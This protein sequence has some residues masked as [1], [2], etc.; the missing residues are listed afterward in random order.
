MPSQPDEVGTDSPHDSSPDLR[1][2]QVL[3][4]GMV[5]R[6]ESGGVLTV[7]RLKKLDALLLKIVKQGS[8]DSRERNIEILDR[9]LASLNSVVPSEI[10]EI[11]K[12]ETGRKRSALVKRLR[13][14]L[15]IAGSLHDAAAPAAF[16]P[17]DYKALGRSI[18][19][20]L[21]NSDAHVMPP[22]SK[23]FGVGVY[24]LYYVGNFA[25]Y[26]PLVEKHGHAAKVP[27]YVGKAVPEGARIGGAAAGKAS[28][29]G[30]LHEHG[31]SIGEAKSTLQL[32]DF[33][34]RFLIVEPAFVPLCEVALL[35]EHRPLWNSWLHGFGS[36][37][38]GSGR[39]KTRK[40]LWD[41]LHPGRERAS[42]F[43]DAWD[44]EE[45]KSQVERHLRGEKVDQ[46]L[47]KL[48]QKVAPDLDGAD[49][50]DVS[51]DEGLDTE[52][53]SGS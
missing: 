43:Q 16:N 25:P 6:A 38:A 41:T 14:V 50:D 10:I 37:A 15:K 47:L 34:Y 24:A 36:N 32:E 21:N 33:R 53:S 27:I 42:G 8:P 5:S 1:K 52:E 9:A 48:A 45:L 12:I 3:V 20:E 46:G 23:F 40:S 31:R 2:L 11:L 4:N 51:A 29:Y 39:G 22:T 28:L 49:A 30:R 26:R 44:T 13:A 18:A 19:A 17:L 35:G 7:E